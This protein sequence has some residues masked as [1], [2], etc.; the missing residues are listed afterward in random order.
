MPLPDLA[1]QP[2]EISTAAREI[3]QSLDET[4]WAVNPRNDNLPHLISYLSEFATEFLAVAGVRCRLDFPDYLPAHPI[5]T[6]A[7]HNLFMAVK[8]ALNNAV[9]HARATEVRLRA[10]VSDEALI[11]TVEDD[12][13]GFEHSSGQKADSISAD[14]LRNM[15]QRMEEIGGR[16][17]LEST[18]QKGTKVTLTFFWVGRQKGTSA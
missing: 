11:L 2:L 15:S 1:R 17:N 13:R 16:F 7:R 5:A 8:E 6:E 9:R 14:G 10:A 4:V 18:P 12:G 3:I